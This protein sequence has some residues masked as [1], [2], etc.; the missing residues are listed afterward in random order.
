MTKYD[1][2]NPDQLPQ[3]AVE[4]AILAPS[5]MPDMPYVTRRWMTHAI[6]AFLN[7]LLEDEEAMERV[8]QTLGFGSRGGASIWGI[9]LALI[10]AVQ[11]PN[12]PYDPDC[13]DPNHMGIRDLR[14]DP[15]GPEAIAAQNKKGNADGQ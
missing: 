3:A 15:S 7:A 12:C 9:R 14:A 5:D 11:E 10:A 1:H 2:I 13:T 6:A 8:R 4:K